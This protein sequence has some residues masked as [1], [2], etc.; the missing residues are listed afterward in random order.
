VQGAAF[1]GAVGL[2]AACDMAVA[3][4][5]ASFCI[6]EVKLGIIP[7]VISPFLLEAIGIRAAR[8]YAL[9]AQFFYFD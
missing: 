5:S 2:V 9:T 1:G 3:S 6:S 4:T 7:A 8:R